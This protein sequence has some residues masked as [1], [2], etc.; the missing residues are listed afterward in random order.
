[1]R[2]KKSLGQNFLNNKDS[3][4]AVVEA[5]Q[6]KAEQIVLEVGPGRGAL[7]SLL[8]QKGAQV[9]AVEKDPDLVRFL[10]TKF[11]K[12]IETKRL[13]LITKDI[14]DF[15]PAYLK[16][17]YKIIANIPYYITGALLRKIFSS[18]NLPSRMVLMLQKEV[19]QRIVANDKKE[20]LLSISV[21]VYGRPTCIRTVPA[22]E[23]NPAPKVDSAVLLI[24]EISKD[25]FKTLKE[26]DI[27]EKTF[28]QTIKKGFSQ[29]RKTLANNLSSLGIDKKELERHIQSLG[30]PKSARAE[31][32]SVRDWEEL[33]LL[34]H[35]GAGNKSKR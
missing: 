9:M 33:L 25:Y 18:P 34:L 11:K 4:E 1:M 10:Q 32:L 30:L 21:K 20:S 26:N 12:E 28:F 19:A 27:N 8:L 13:Q 15:E 17:N 3:L 31:N 5:G 14:L 22:H 24:K 2:P 29:K 7:T 23:F 35:C 16:K 6:V